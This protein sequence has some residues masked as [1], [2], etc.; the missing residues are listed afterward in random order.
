MR[1]KE[2]IKPFLKY[3]EDM[4]LEY[5]DYRFGQLL[6]NIGISADWHIE[7][8]NQNIPHYYLRDIQHWGT[9]NRDY[10]KNPLIQVPVSELSTDHIE[11]ILRTQNHISNNLKNIFKNELGYREILEM[12]M[13]LNIEEQGFK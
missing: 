5:P 1:K 4:W 12:E 8:T 13:Q 7:D 3:I 10:T 9:Y 6:S 2:R 11:A